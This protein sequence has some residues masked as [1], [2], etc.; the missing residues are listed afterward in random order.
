V[1]LNHLSLSH[2]CPYIYCVYGR[3]ERAFVSI[4]CVYGRSAT[5]VHFHLLCIR[6]VSHVRSSGDYQY[7]HYFCSLKRKLQTFFGCLVCF[8]FGLFREAYFGCV[9]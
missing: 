9:D 1:Y 7:T 5:C 8:N 4:Y 2:K 6:P 3:S